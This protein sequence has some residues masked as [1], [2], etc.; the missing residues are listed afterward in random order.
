MYQ[1]Q[2]QLDSQ[3][4]EIELMCRKLEDVE[5]FQIPIESELLMASLNKLQTILFLSM[6]RVVKA[7]H[8]L[9][10][11][12]HQLSPYVRGVYGFNSYP[13]W[14]EKSLS[15]NFSNK[16]KILWLDQYSCQYVDWFM[17]LNNEFV[18]FSDA[19]LRQLSKLNHIHFSFFRYL[20][21]RE[22]QFREAQSLKLD[23]YS[24]A[25]WIPCFINSEVH[26][27]FPKSQ[28]LGP[29]LF[30]LNPV[31][32]F[33]IY[34]FKINFNGFSNLRLALSSLWTNIFHQKFYLLG[35]NAM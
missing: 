17:T 5:E 32:V 4:W 13:L 12:Y 19:F 29:I 30:L 33:V 3:L 26:Y 20:S 2:W 31:H 15:T 7:V 25:Q 9:L 1:L 23:G 35:Y 24:T 22:H 14:N 10:F 34:R 8:D 16:I 27:L 21:I 6:V 18:A 11:Y 28:P